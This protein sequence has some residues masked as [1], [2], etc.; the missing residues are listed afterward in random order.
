MP[1]LR[2]SVRNCRYGLPGQTLRVVHVG[3]GEE[4]RIRP[5]NGKAERAFA[6]VPL[7]PGH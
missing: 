2:R 6:V 7:R 5:G 4:L 3:Q 1:W